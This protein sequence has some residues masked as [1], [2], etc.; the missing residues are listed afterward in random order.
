M[1]AYIDEQRDVFGVEPICQVLA[2]APS[3]YYA[4]RDH[5][6]GRL[7]HRRH[8]SALLVATTSVRK[9]GTRWS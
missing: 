8:V 5:P 4:A 3:T 6:S 9:G 7:S 2:I 1:T